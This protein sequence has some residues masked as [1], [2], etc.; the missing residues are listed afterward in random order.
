MHARPVILFPLLLLALLAML[1]LWIDYVVQAPEPKTDGSSRHDPDFIM[2]NFVT[3]RT[4][5]NGNPRYVLAAAEMRHYPDDETT[6]LVRPR[7][8]QYTVDQPYTQIEGQRGTVSK[9]GETVEVMDNVKVTRQASADSA[10]LVIN[11]EYLHI[12]PDKDLVKTDRPVVI[13]QGKTV[14]RGTGM[15][16]NKELQTVQLQ[17]NVRVHYVR[18]AVKSGKK[19]AAKPGSKKR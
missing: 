6:E 2:N 11:T 4:D 7:F 13:T 18:P 12:T 17:K 9:D 5:L 8:T 14:I 3:K 16:Y 15:I 19:A 10:E 1:T